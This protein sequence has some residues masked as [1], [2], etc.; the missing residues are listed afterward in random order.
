[1]KQ[2]FA[3]IFGRSIKKRGIAMLTGVIIIAVGLGSLAGCQTKVSES[4][5]YTPSASAAIAEPSST[6]TDSSSQPSITP[7]SI[8]PPSMSPAMSFEELRNLI[9]LTKDELL[10][11]IAETPVTVDEG[12]L[13]FDK[14]GIR[15]WFD[16]ATYKTVAQV[17]ILSDS[18][19][20][21][22]VKLGDSL[23]KFEKIF[24]KSISNSNGDA[25][26]AYGSIYLSVN[27]DMSTNKIFAVYIL[28]DN[29]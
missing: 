8:T 21:N 10:A 18:I 16:T 13:G 15:I 14:T 3:N 23:T 9:G 28:K 17:L 12:G 25:H 24:G 5:N 4:P 26:F 20:I 2:R 22:G 27:Y 1:M 11:K 7:S 6:A 29:F 19:D